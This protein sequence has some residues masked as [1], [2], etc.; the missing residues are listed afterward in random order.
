MTQQT[1]H[2]HIYQH[3][4]TDKIHMLAH[5]SIYYVNMCICIY[6]NMYICVNK[7]IC[8]NKYIYIYMCMYNYKYVNIYIY[9]HICQAC[10]HM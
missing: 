10:G 3:I 4:R 6:K 9:I 7:Y 1:L 8:I 5:T 2:A